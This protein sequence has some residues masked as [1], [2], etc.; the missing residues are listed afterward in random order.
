VT[1][2]KATTGSL[3]DALT[4][5]P[6]RAHFLDLARRSFAR[7]RR[8][9]GDRLAILFL[10]VDRFKPVTERLGNAAGDELLV[11]MGEAA[12]DL[13]PRRRYA[14]A[15]RAGT[16]SASCSTTSRNRQTPNRG[17]AHP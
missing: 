17:P 8:R 13:P 6:N 14:R 1:E 9:E 2:P 16:I 15:A 10:D 11:K 4:G 7:T 5:L 12:P 3:H